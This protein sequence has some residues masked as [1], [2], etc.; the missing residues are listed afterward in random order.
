MKR[1]ELI[2]K[3][4]IVILVISFV[5]IPNIEKVNADFSLYGV[6]YSDTLLKNISFKDISRHWAETPIKKMAAHNLIRGYTTDTFRPNV[7]IPKEQVIAIIIR[8]I[9]LEEVAQKKA[10]TDLDMPI[11]PG[12]DGDIYTYS[13]WSRGYLHEAYEQGILTE[14]EFIMTQWQEPAERQEAAYWLAKALKLPE[15]YGSELQQIYSLNDWRDIDEE[16][17]IQIESI[18]KEDIMSGTPE[19]KF[20]PKD[21][22]T[23]A[24]MAAIMERS[25]DYFLPYTDLKKLMGTITSLT[26]E[27][28][29]TGTG[30]IRKEIY[31]VL[32]LSGETVNIVVEDKVINNWQRESN[33]LVVLKNGK[34]GSSSLLY[35]NDDI[36]IYLDPNDRVTFIEVTKAFNRKIVDGEIKNIKHDETGGEITIETYAGSTY[37]FKLSQGL[38]PMIDYRKAELRDLIEG[39]EITLTSVDGTAVSI[40]ALTGLEEG[41]ITPESRI[42]RGRIR[43]IDKDTIKIINSEGE[44]EA[45]K[46]S[47]YTDITKNG[48]KING[49]DLSTGEKVMLFFD[50]LDTDEV[51]RITVGGPQGKI[52]TVYKGRLHRADVR[53]GE[54][55]LEN[56]SEYYYGSW[57]EHQPQMK[58]N[59]NRDTQIFYD[60]RAVSI[61][62]LE[63]KYRGSYIY[64]SVLPGYGREEGLTIAI[65]D[66]DEISDNGKID[67]ISW[68]S[69][70]IETG[71]SIIHTNDATVFLNN[72]NIVD[73]MDLD[74][75]A[76]IFY[77][78]LSKGSAKSGIIINMINF[79]PSDYRIFKGDL[80]EITPQG[81]IIDRYSEYEEN[82]WSSPRSSRRRQEFSLYDD[83]IILDTTLEFDKEVS[84]RDFRYA[85]FTHDYYDWHT[86]IISRDDKA[87]GIMLIPDDRGI[88][89]ITS[90]GKIR[91]KDSKEK[92]IM[93]DSLI[94]W[95]DFREKWNYTFSELEVFLEDTLIIK[96]GEI[97]RY[98]DLQVGDTLYIVRNNNNGIIAV[99]QNGMMGG[100]R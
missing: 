28:E 79:Y 15:L 94:D 25:M 64:V 68:M 17:L 34:L 29:S 12:Q 85:R 3:I 71:N 86:Y 89:E 9:G 5:A 44:E 82:G 60:G 51:S 97:I 78:S 8:A 41:Y 39:Q 31:N 61:S 33:D 21:N 35:P 81:F 42:S 23:R 1:Y 48:H 18:L 72:G 92:S 47:N 84:L 66:D 20:K 14:Q 98:E 49:N 40:T 32:L 83:T 90:I 55:V 74:E 38:K 99:V 46:I 27:T 50:Y 80:Y 88:D 13:P 70:V 16:Y 57:T 65:K 96:N 56:V 6:E 63:R 100:T 58:L 91:W 69:G 87:V 4:L 45:Y 93:L 19:R 67:S 53:Q 22:M 54:L 11:M 7:S 2:Q 43:D 76:H 24:E 95:N 73:I 37:R 36:I 10:G 52:K 59:L 77:T 62:D 26:S 30:A 75:K